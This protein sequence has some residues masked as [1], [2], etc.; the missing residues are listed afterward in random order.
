MAQ[1]M[2]V[3]A[4]DIMKDWG[5]LKSKS[6]SDHRRPLRETVKDESTFHHHTG[7]M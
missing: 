3:D 7:E 6:L 5:V 1:K 2:Y 4:N